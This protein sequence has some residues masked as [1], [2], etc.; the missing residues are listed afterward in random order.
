MLSTCDIEVHVLVL[1]DRYVFPIISDGPV[2]FR[3]SECTVSQALLVVGDQVVPLKCV[4]AVDATELT[5]DEGLPIH[6]NLI[7]RQE[8]S[9]HITA[10]ALPN[11]CFY[12]NELEKI[13][14][15]I[16]LRRPFTVAYDGQIQHYDG[17]YMHGE[18]QLETI[19]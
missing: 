2:R 5:L 17:V 10:D 6:M 13:T 14:S 9:C 3:V 1:M 19:T 18:L 8:V 11:F 12:T 15:A 16:Y 4:D 7:T